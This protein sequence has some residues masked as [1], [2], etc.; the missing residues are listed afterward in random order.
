MLLGSCNNVVT[1]NASFKDPARA[2]E[3]ELKFEVY[4]FEIL[5]F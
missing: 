4:G 5:K 2:L 1:P 3:A